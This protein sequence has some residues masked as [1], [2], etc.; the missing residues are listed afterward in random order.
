MIFYGADLE[1]SCSRGSTALYVSAQNGHLEIVKELLK[2]NAN[3]DTVF[4]NSHRKRKPI[5]IARENGHKQIEKVLAKY[6]NKMATSSSNNEYKYL[7]DSC[8]FKDVPK[9]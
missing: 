3:P 7:R 1:Q 2:N 4:D 5:D 6:M 9:K 8:G